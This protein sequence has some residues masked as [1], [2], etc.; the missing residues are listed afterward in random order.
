VKTPPLFLVPPAEPVPQP[1]Q[2]P[3]PRP[4]SFY[5]WTRWWAS[6][7]GL[8]E[9]DDEVAVDTSPPVPLREVLR[10]F[11][12][13]ARRYRHWLWLAL[14]VAAISPS[15][16][17]ATIWLFKVVVDGVLIPH[18]LKLF[19]VL[20][21][22]YLALTAA[23]GTISFVSSYASVWVGENF[24]LDLRSALFDH[25]TRLSPFFYERHPLGDVMSR[26]STDIGNIENLLISSAASLVSSVTQLLF[27][28]AALIY[29]RWDLALVA[30]LA[31]PVFWYTG[32]HFS[33]RIRS[34]SR[35]QRRR[36]GSLSAVAQES[37]TNIALVQAYGREDR[38]KK[39]FLSQNRARLIAQMAATRLQ[40]LFTPIVDVVEMAGVMVVLGV[41]TLELA[42][43]RLTLGG[44]M[45]FIAYMAQVYGP[46]RGLA[47][48]STSVYAASA[49]AERVIE[50]F[51][52]RPAV[53]E[54]PT[55]V[56]LGRA[57]GE[58]RLHRVG[59]RYPGAE[60][61]T[62]SELTFGLSPGEVVAV[63]GPSGAGKSTL[64]KLLLRFDD[65]SFGAITLDG[66]DLRALD[67]AS[68]RR[69][70]AV[71]L[72]DTL[73]FSGTIRENILFGRP[74][75]TERQLLEAARLA[76]LDEFVRDLPEGYD[77]VVG[78]QGRRLSGGQRQRLAIARALVRDAPL[79]VLDEPTAGLDSQ[80]EARV[81]EPLRRLMVGRTTLVISH[82]FLTVREATR[83]V[84]LESGRMTD[85]GTHH[86]LV[87]R[88][89]VYAALYE[90]AQGEAAAGPPLPMEP[91]LALVR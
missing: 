31:A 61:D 38:E 7:L 12:P 27:L 90:A 77:T 47:G 67:L 9:D 82:S 79:V 60:Q 85:Q 44:L 56:R 71:V 78:Q 11:W 36:N 5:G 65:P 54:L 30:L 84:V 52:E 10:R 4:S 75:A 33:R 68:L 34:A 50:V 66:R 40:A 86:E 35:E 28:S 45:A 24:L 88:S 81:A 55:A 6:R 70:I 49:S 87:R 53:A 57:T 19:P 13:Y 59:Y 37:L 16:D 74:D 32:A 18:D 83:I 26:L 1:P 62:L 72:Q 69:N 80:A 39:R 21:G 73:V 42:H 51:D 23:G 3:A 14:F 76:D 15:I 63:V 43:G 22:A 8:A 29:L 91:R 46:I 25:L 64:V 41:G 20:V 2:Q 58:L 48:L 17:A 89:R